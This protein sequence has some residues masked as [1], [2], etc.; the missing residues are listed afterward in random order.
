MANKPPGIRLV[1][2]AYGRNP[3]YPVKVAH[4]YTDGSG[5]GNGLPEGAPPFGNCDMNSADG[6]T[7][8]QFARACGVV[9]T[10]SAAVQV[11]T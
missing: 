10:D 7:A 4:Q 8:T 3:S 2:A 6:L 1:V 5:Y 9:I 11:A